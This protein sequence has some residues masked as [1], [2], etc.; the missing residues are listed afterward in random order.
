MASN[1]E[2]GHAKNIANFE[3]LITRCAGYG[4]DY[5]PSNPLLDIDALRTLH[6]ESKVDLNQV[7]VA[8][9][10]YDFIEGKRKTMF[11]PYGSLATQIMASLQS[12]GASE[13]VINDAKTI[14]RKM[15]GRRAPGTMP[16]TKEGETPK[17]RISVSQQ[18]YDMKIEH[19]DKMIEHLNIETAY[20]PNE[21]KLKIESLKNYKQELEVINSKVKN[22]Y[23]P[24]SQAL[25]ARNRKLYAPETGL[26]ARAQLVKKYVK[27]IYKTQSPEYKM[28]SKLPF[29]FLVEIQ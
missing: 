26:V 28:I 12:S 23:V 6:T 13:T 8:K 22:A 10:P 29:K 1:S 15:Q 21:E 17:D 11:Q 5:N 27:S 3:T 19:L 24:Y 18:S 9:S 14:Y 16:E 20:R 25:N 2:T 4:T 7:S